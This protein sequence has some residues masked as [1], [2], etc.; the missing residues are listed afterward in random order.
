[1]SRLILIRPIHHSSLINLETQNA[2]MKSTA[3]NKV[4]HI[5]KDAIRSNK[6]IFTDDLAKIS[7]GLN[8]PDTLPLT[9]SSKQIICKGDPQVS[10][11]FFKLWYRI[12]KFQTNRLKTTIKTF[13]RLQKTSKP[14]KNAK[15]LQALDL[16]TPAFQISR[17]E[18]VESHRLRIVKSKLPQLLLLTLIF[19]EMIIPIFH[20]FPKLGIRPLLTTRALRQLSKSY[21]FEKRVIKNDNFA[22]SPY[23]LKTGELEALL[24]TLFSCPVPNW[25]ITLWSKLNIKWRLAEVLTDIHQ[26]LIVDDW[27][28]LKDIT[29]ESK[30]ISSISFNE[31]V[32]FVLERQLFYNGE[33]LNAM[34]HSE[35]GRN[36][37]IWRLIC[38][39]SFKFDQ[40]GSSSFTEKWGV[41][42]VSILNFP[43]TKISTDKI[44]L[45]TKQHLKYF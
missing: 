4:F 13:Y 45:V 35:D 3:T 24:K 20:F 8:S 42:N 19:E 32:N 30:E 37:L 7:R 15:I 11:H 36:V 14:L 6:L 10:S 44:G 2:F 23:H 16:P 40:V 43:G 41:N 18:V 22:M 12:L 34:V 31:L 29:N 33:D 39:L 25:R 26:F 9:L 21:S 1:M 27:L 38:Y 5:L 17:R 28:L